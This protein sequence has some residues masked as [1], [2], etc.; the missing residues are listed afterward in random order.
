MIVKARYLTETVLKIQCLLVKRVFFK[1][2]CFG[3]CAFNLL[4]L[5]NSLLQVGTIIKEVEMQ[6]D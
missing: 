3:H 2:L 1:H 4:N 6:R 5:C